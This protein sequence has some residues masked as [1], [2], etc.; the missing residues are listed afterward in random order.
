MRPGG[1]GD[2]G[3]A[4]YPAGDPPGAVPVQAVPVHGAEDRSFAALADGQV[5]GP[6]G[7]RRERDGDDRAALTGDDRGPVAALDAG[8]L[9][10]RA[11]GLADPQAVDGPQADQGM[12]GGR[13]GPG[14]G[15]QCADLVAVQAGG[16]RLIVQ[17]R[18]ADMH[19][20]GTVRQFLPGGVPAGTPATVHS[21]RV[22]AARARPR[23]PRSRAKHAMPARR[24]LNRRR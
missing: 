2:P 20:R 15:Q 9:D 5:D 21:R 10:V 16:V 17:A 18:P 7:P 22:M 8:G 4:G 13:A 6:R 3:A 12:P 23:A 11:G 24:T 14:G 19:C 1:R